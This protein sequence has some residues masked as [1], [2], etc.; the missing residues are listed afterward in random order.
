MT[1]KIKLIFT[2]NRETFSI[3]ILNKVI[4][5]QDR[6]MKKGIQ[7]MPRDAAVRR[8]IILSRN[9]IP[10]WILGWIEEANSGKNLLEY[11]SAQTDEDLVP[12]IKKDAGEKGCLFHDK[13]YIEVDD[14]LIK[15]NAE[16]EK[17]EVIRLAKEAENAQNKEKAEIVTTSQENDTQK[18]LGASTIKEL[19]KAE[20]NPHG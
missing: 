16:K 1:K 13:Q 14:M 2:I 18:P 12:I 17:E 15:A 9:R 8:L 3:E 10:E 11:Q 19:N 4:T 20:V 5:Y 6:R 7:F